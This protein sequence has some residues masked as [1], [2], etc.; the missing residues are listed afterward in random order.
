MDLFVFVYVSFLV[1]GYDS[2]CIRTKG[3]I[4]WATEMKMWKI[5][6]ITILLN[7]WIKIGIYKNLFCYYHVV[8]KKLWN[9][10]ILIIKRLIIINN[11][12]TIIAVLTGLIC[13]I[14]LFKVG[15]NRNVGISK[16]VKC[17]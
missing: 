1:L 10:Q 16:T 6:G 14:Y 8:L 11:F 15:L 3:K 4:S 9:Q 13:W 7:L 5:Q 12:K 17:F 2:E